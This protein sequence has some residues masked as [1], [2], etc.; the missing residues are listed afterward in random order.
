MSPFDVACLPA[1][2]RLDVLV[3]GML[4]LRPSTRRGLLDAHR[5]ACRGRDRVLWRGETLAQSYV[6]TA[7]AAGKGGADTVL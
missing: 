1:T 3:A 4:K 7:L 2:A 5:L 6:A